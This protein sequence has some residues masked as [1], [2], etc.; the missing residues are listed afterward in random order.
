MKGK[1]VKTFAQTRQTYTDFD[2]MKHWVGSRPFTGSTPIC[3]TADV[4]TYQVPGTSVVEWFFEVGERVITRTEPLN[5]PLT[6]LTR[7]YPSPEVEGDLRFLKV[8]GI[9]SSDPPKASRLPSEVR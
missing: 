2:G 7:P 1:G 6:P 8:T 9:G 4:V 5:P 3:L